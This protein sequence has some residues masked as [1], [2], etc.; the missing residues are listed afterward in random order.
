MAVDDTLWE[1]TA[2]TRDRPGSVHAPAGMRSAL[3]ALDFHRG[4][5]RSARSTVA[6][7]GTPLTWNFRYS[8]VSGPT[9]PDDSN[10]SSTASACTTPVTAADD[11]ADERSACAPMTT[12]GTPARPTARAV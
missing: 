1:D 10:A 4:N 6:P 3:R 12:P 9:R 7:F 2:A 8:R 5:T 11:V